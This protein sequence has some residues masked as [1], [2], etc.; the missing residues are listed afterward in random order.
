MREPSEESL[1]GGA[2]L[3][4]MWHRRDQ[5]ARCKWDNE[6]PLFHQRCY[7]IKSF[8]V[9]ITSPISSYIDS[10]TIYVAEEAKVCSRDQAKGHSR[11]RRGFRTVTLREGK[12]KQVVEGSRKG[13]VAGDAS[14][15]VATLRRCWRE[16]HVTGPGAGYTC[17]G[18]ARKR[19]IVFPASPSM[20]W[21]VIAGTWSVI[22]FRRRPQ[23]A[24]RAVFCLWC[25]WGGD[26][27]CE[28]ELRPA[29]YLCVARKR[30]EERG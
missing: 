18:P 3:E 21:H 28:V 25:D 16:S 19:L 2:L 15:T 4:L 6:I 20:S 26:W 12:L 17:R 9:I 27:F 23:P 22:S 10:E 30:G 5:T 14:G 7:G 29:L 8:K 11:P 24:I 13:F 1:R